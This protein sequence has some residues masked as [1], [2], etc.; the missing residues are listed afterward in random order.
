MEKYTCKN[1]KMRIDTS[2]KIILAVQSLNPA[3][4]MYAHN[5]KIYENRIKQDLETCGVTPEFTAAQIIKEFTNQ[6]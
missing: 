4:I 3:A 1:K 6:S 5:Y 2:V